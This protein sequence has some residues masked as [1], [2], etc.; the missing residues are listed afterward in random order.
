MAKLPNRNNAVVSL[1]KFTEYLLNPEHPTGRHK[2]RVFKAA[3][4]LTLE[5]AEFLRNTAQ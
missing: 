4:G 1:E 3:L 2:A 5:N